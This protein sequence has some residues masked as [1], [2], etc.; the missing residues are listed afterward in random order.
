MLLTYDEFNMICEEVS[1]H[2]TQPEF[3]DPARDYLS[4]II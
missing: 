1:S 4:P 2:F 3:E